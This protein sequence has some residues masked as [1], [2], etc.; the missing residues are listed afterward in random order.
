MRIRT[1]LIF[2]LIA[3]LVFASIDKA[4]GIKKTFEQTHK[5]KADVRQLEKNETGLHIE[6]L[7]IYQI[8]SYETMPPKE[9]FVIEHSGDLYASEAFSTDDT[10]EMALVYIGTS[11]PERFH[12]R[13]LL[14]SIKDIP[15][16]V[17]KKW[18]DE[19]EPLSKKGNKII[20]YTWS[21]TN[22]VLIKWTL[23]TKKSK[24]EKIKWEVLAIGIGDA[25]L[26]W[27]HASVLIGDEYEEEIEDEPEEVTGL[28]PS[29]TITVND[30]YL[31]ILWTET[32]INVETV[33]VDLVG[34][35]PSTTVE[36]SVVLFSYPVS[37]MGSTIA[38][39]INVTN[40]TT[41][42]AGEYTWT[43]TPQTDTHS[44]V[45]DIRAVQLSD[46]TNNASYYNTAINN[47][48]T[49][50]CYFI[51]EKIAQRNSSDDN[52]ICKAYYFSASFGWDRTRADEYANDSSNA[53]ANAYNIDVL[54]WGFESPDPDQT[55]QVFIT[56]GNNIESA[57]FD[58]DQ[59]AP[60]DLPP[61]AHSH[62][63]NDGR[64]CTRVNLESIIVGYGWEF[65]TERDMQNV[66]IE[67]E[68][69]HNLQW[70]ANG[71]AGR[72]TNVEGMARNSES[73]AYPNASTWVNGALT[74]STIDE[75]NSYLL[76]TDRALGA[77][78][79]SYALVWGFIYQ[80][81][82][83]EAIRGIEYNLTNYAEP[84]DTGLENIIDQV[85]ALPG[86]HDSFG[87]VIADLAI[88]IY[89]KNFTWGEADGSNNQSWGQYH[90]NV[91]KTN[92]VWSGDSATVAGTINRWGIDFINVRNASFQNIII[93][94]D[95]S[96][97]YAIYLIK[98]NGSEY[99]IEQ[100]ILDGNFDGSIIFGNAADY[101]EGVL[102]IAK[103]SSN[104]DAIESY[105]VVLA[106]SSEEHN[107]IVTEITTVPSIIQQEGTVSVTATIWNFGTNN[108]SDIEIK[109]LQNGTEYTNTTIA[110]LETLTS[111]VVSLNW[112]NST[113]IG[114][115]NLTIYVVP[116]TGETET[117]DNQQSTEITVTDKKIL[118]IDDDGG[119]LYETYFEN[120]LAAN[121]YDYESWNTDTQ[122][123]PNSDMVDEFQ[124]V[125]WFTGQEYSETITSDEAA[126]LQNYLD[127][128][129]SL[130]LSGQEV[131]YYAGATAF[132]GDYLKAFYLN[133][134]SGINSVQGIVDDSIT[135]GMAL[136][137]AGGD[138]ADDN[139]FPDEILPLDGSTEIFTY[140]GDGYAGLRY[141]D[142][143]QL[144][145]LAFNFETVNS[146]NDRNIL[147]KKIIE[148]LDVEPPTDLSII[149]NS[150][151]ANTGN[152]TVSLTLHAS[153]ATTL[154]C[155]YSNNGTEYTNY[156]NYST[157]KTWNLTSELGNKTVYYQCKDGNGNEAEPVN[158]SIILVSSWAGTGTEIQQN[159]PDGYE[160]SGIVWHPY[161]DSLFLVGDGGNISKIDIDG[162]NVVNW[163]IG[164]DFE[165]VSVANQNLDYVYVAVE[166]PFEIIRFN[167]SQG[168][169]SAQISL[170]GI[171]PATGNPNSGIEGIAY[172]P[173]GDHPYS[174]S[175]A[176]GLF[177]F[178]VQENG[179][180]YVVDVDFGLSTATLIDSFIPVP[181]R[182]DI[183][184]LFFSTETETLYVLYDTDN[185]IREITSNNTYITEYPA[186]GL[187]QEG[188]TFLPACPNTETTLFIAEDSGRVMRYENYPINCPD[189]YPPSN[190]QFV[191]PTLE[192]TSITNRSWIY[193]NVTFTEPN[194]DSCWVVWNNG[195][196]T[197]ISM[198]RTDTNCYVNVTDQSNGVINYSV[199]VNDSRGNT[200]SSSSRTII[201]QDSSPVWCGFH[202]M[203]TT[204]SD[205]DFEQDEFT[206]TLKMNYD[207]AG[208]NDHDTSLDQTEWTDIIS[209]TNADNID[210][211]FTYFFGAE[212]TST[213][214]HIYYITANPNTT[215]MSAAN[216]DFNTVA[217]LA[218]WLSNNQGFGEHNHPA[219]N[220]G[221]Q[222]DFSDPT[223]TNDSWIPL[224]DMQN[225][226]EWHWNYYWNCSD[227]SGCTNYTNPHD[228]SGGHPEGTGWV[229]YAL[230]NG[231][232]LGFSCS[233]DDHSSPFSADCFIGL[234]NPPNWTRLG[235]LETVLKR[236]TWAAENKTIMQVT[237]DNGS[238]VYIMGD[239]F[240]S[241][242]PNITI[243]YTI[244]ASDGLLIANVSLF[245][246]GVI[247]NHTIVNTAN[248][249]GSFIQTL[250]PGE[251]D[252]IFIQ[253]TQNNGQMAWSSPMWITFVDLTQPNVSLIQ[254]IEDYNTNDSN[255]SFRWNV[256]D[257]K[258]L[259][260]TC[261]LYV[262][263]VGSGI[264]V[265]T[266][267]ST[268][269]PHS[270]GL[271]DDGR[272]NWSVNCSDG[273]NIG[274]S[275]VRNFTVD[276]N[277]PTTILI[278]PSD[279]S[280]TTDTT[281]TFTF[282]YTDTTSP[283]ANC[284]LYVD[285]DLEATDTTVDNDTNTQLTSSVL[286][287]GDHT[288]YVICTDLAG[289]S[290][291]SQEWDLIITSGG[292]GGG[293][294]GGGGGSGGAATTDK[295][296]TIIHQTNV[297]K[298]ECTIDSECSDS[299][300]CLGGECKEV[301]GICGYAANHRWNYYDCCWDNEC[302][303]NQICS[304]NSCLTIEV[305][306]PETNTT[307]NITIKKNESCIDC[308][309][310]EPIEK[311]DLDASLTIIGAVAVVG[312]VGA[313]LGAAVFLLK[314][315]KIESSKT[316]RKKR[317]KS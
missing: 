141:N 267:G 158:T 287:L 97:D 172:V 108:E 274:Y 197:N 1:I 296:V 48:C 36:I 68:F 161:F 283:T 32:E 234:A 200:N 253:A 314:K 39:T 288:W 5:V 104:G 67:H 130:F 258:A 182:T 2:I 143:Y 227:G 157:T 153:D 41:D 256:T 107:L 22:G 270:I 111:T 128:N 55:F 59:N 124:I 164:G 100:I 84:Y 239:I 135:N 266:N 294:G 212:W 3:S 69:Y 16:K 233:S 89:T 57:W 4:P 43:Y 14:E 65:E 225:K 290:D 54:D 316:T 277:N 46:P 6:N 257:D 285:D 315:P 311:N 208:W 205:G 171:I 211:N 51:I 62:S 245:Y 202:S 76:N 75:H 123:I 45:G 215:V 27:E 223:K 188:I 101:D 178:G 236:H 189:V 250:R 254:P 73:I 94:F 138:G 268:T 176:G 25:E 207:C 246:N 194:P 279:G 272:H 163:N 98:K 52:F 241:L 271:L 129:K 240:A 93:L 160:P 63:G 74:A 170:T 206:S 184:D 221:S 302:G 214:N 58:P 217:E 231:H 26:D 147:M 102:A 265:L 72:N 118:L 11:N 282:R 142:S 17:D 284:S 134:D 166:Y 85:V 196:I 210:G 70:G 34:F 61:N 80:H 300:A 263:E 29:Q 201:I 185:F 12:V 247:V 145:Y 127:E 222:T 60:R 115:Y 299:K 213:S 155:H 21:Q 249:S 44:G 20:A 90:D 252:Y 183:S 150:G 310:E 232:H 126:V 117:D 64:F 31:D 120:A 82:G 169:V 187:N 40:I 175:S 192:N 113:N 83:I 116:V 9:S 121:N 226:G 137:L 238:A 24:I 199:Y 131:G 96:S 307:T 190:I 49:T 262:D 292:S 53:C 219:R 122:G 179:V 132:Y 10:D 301:T 230:D 103:N 177:Y 180:I 218:E 110:G 7:K 162:A 255:V 42:G 308:K 33:Q 156:E 229:K 235:V 260:L 30:S 146:A 136:G 304:N 148:W 66:I 224:V 56:N 259:S 191:A 286:S 38:Q 228:P 276:T 144:V 23:T 209:R 181:G 151:A 261:S 47:G 50:D 37:G 119:D 168:V 295:N 193:I 195:S 81:N 305:Q 298:P 77:F 140:T 281:P 86:G 133:D 15:G 114:N 248:T 280:S 278:S 186:P 19:I 242:S 173:N 303:T 78:S 204:Y 159:L 8:L 244:N 174:N 152:A 313:A 28:Y 99:T 167:A 306:L 297:T 35:D 293:G 312:V 105:S 251:E 109:L 95:G 289:N 243:D 139:D 125:V 291:L 106:G 264:F 149:I 203:H 237:A 87:E 71:W 13:K 91:T 198:T 79:Y 18:K 273:Y 275:E 165:G 269:G 154:Q 220:A 112:S 317:K 216:P 309:K 88:A 92:P